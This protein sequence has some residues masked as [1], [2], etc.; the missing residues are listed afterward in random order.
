MG[1]EPVGDRYESY[2]EYLTVKRE[3]DLRSY[4]GFI[5]SWFI[6]GGGG[7]TLRSRDMTPLLEL[8]PARNAPTNNMW[9]VEDYPECRPI[10][11][12]RH[13]D[14]LVEWSLPSGAKLVDQ[15]RI[16]R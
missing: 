14:E 13:C 3:S 11:Y 9:N 1:N 5:T 7:L 4:T 8:T 12:E 16:D 6:L 2:S 10:L 15:L